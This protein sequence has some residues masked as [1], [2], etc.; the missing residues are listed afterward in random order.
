[1]NQV[2][3]YIPRPWLVFLLLT[4]WMSNAIYMHATQGKYIAIIASGVDAA[5]GTDGKYV[6]GTSYA[7]PFVT[8]TDLGARDKDL[9][10][11]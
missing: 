10:F 4:G 1:M 6:S 9:V 2:P 3:L 7:V 5:L 8:A 11:G